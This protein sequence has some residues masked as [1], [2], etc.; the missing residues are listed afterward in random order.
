MVVPGRPLSF[1]IPPQ[2]LFQFLF[3]FPRQNVA[4][5]CFLLCENMHFSCLYRQRGKLE[6][7]VAQRVW[8][9]HP[10]ME[11]LLLS[12]L[13]DTH[14]LSSLLAT[15]MGDEGI[16]GSRGRLERLWG[17]QIAHPRLDPKPEVWI[18]GL[19]DNR[20]TEAGWFQ[21]SRFLASFQAT[22]Q[23]C[24]IKPVM[25]ILTIILQAFGKYHDG[26]FK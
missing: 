17:S 21:W 7:V 12:W 8:K 4:G 15:A 23:F 25:A 16:C 22:L 3:I 14:Q 20:G 10:S 1:F 19:G 6:T 11:N 2:N 26:D 18:K 5:S 13:L 24:I 9:F